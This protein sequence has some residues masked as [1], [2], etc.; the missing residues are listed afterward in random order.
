[1]TD[2]GDEPVGEERQRRIGHNEA[3]YRQV[4]ERIET[5]NETFDALAAGFSIVCECGDLHC[6]EQIRVPG[7]V[8]ERTRSNAHQFIV[9]PGHEIDDVEAVVDDHSEFL[10]VEKALPTSRRVAEDTDPR[11]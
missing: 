5:L 11:P 6:M 7:D 3:L 2:E 8:Y 9:K 1:M 4:N 10:I